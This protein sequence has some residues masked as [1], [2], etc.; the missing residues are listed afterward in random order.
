MTQR[1]GA[2]RVVLAMARAFPG[3]RIYTTLYDPDGTYPEFADLDIVV[4]PLNR[5]GP[6]R[7][8]HRLALPLLAPASSRL[9][10]PEDVVVASSSGWAHGFRA[11]GPKLVYCHSPARWLY[12]T[13]EYAG[14][15]VRGR[16]TS[17]V[18][19]TLRAPLVRWDRRA[20][21]S[22]DRYL[23]NSTVVHARIA[24]VYG[25]DADVLPPPHGVSADGARDPVPGVAE[26]A[27]HGYHL[28]VSRLLPYKNVQQVSA[29]FARMPEEPLLVIG[30]GPLRDQLVTA[31]TPNVRF[32][33]DLTDAQL[34]WAYAGATALIAASLEDFGLTPLEAGAFGKPVLALRDGGYLD[35]VDEGRTGLFFERSEPEQIVD[36]VRAAQDRAWDQQAIRDHVATF[37]EPRFRARLREAVAE[38]LPIDAQATFRKRWQDAPDYFSEENP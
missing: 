12:L 34:R 31:A 22:A 30:A 11:R 28:V 5:V 38:L 15:G 19:G 9:E 14:S 25:L 36:A 20:A 33:Q 23:A 1:G 21:A 2:E 35:T 3:A 37:A 7:R 6:L 10:I 16:L 8:H 13:R 29:A 27:P 32:V 18:A 26:W 4:S 24:D 17:A